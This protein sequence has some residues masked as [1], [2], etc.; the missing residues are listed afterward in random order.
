MQLDPIGRKRQAVDTGKAEGHLVPRSLDDLSLFTYA[1]LLDLYSHASVPSDLRALDGSLRGRAL[2]FLGTGDGP[3][4]RA[5]A[6]LVRGKGFPWEGKTLTARSATDGVGVNRIRLPGLG[7]R[8]LFPFVTKLDASTVDGKPCVFIDYADP[9][10]PFFI[11]AIRDELREVSPG[12]FLGPVFVKSGRKMTLVTW[13]AL[14]GTA[15]AGGSR[16]RAG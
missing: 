3:A 14:T 5:I 4:F 6:A 1:E 9:R 15:S 7:R 13:F 12:L 11:R 16:S 2:A 10:N 8:N